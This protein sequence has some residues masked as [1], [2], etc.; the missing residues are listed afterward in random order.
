MAKG[1]IFVQG[2]YHEMIRKLRAGK[3]VYLENFFHDIAIK[4]EPGNPEYY[5]AKR[6]GGGFYQLKRD[7]NLAC[8]TLL[9]ANQLT[10]KEWL[11]Y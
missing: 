5:T 7:T 3:T 1:K 6:M 2:N 9:E 4:V 8:E 11:N 10:E